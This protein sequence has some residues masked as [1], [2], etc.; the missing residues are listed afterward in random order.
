M[1]KADQIRYL[2]GKGYSV[3]EIASVVGCR[4][5]YVRVCAR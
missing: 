5:E 1:T 2:Y 4:A 3:K